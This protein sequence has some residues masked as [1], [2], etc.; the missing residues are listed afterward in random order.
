MFDRKLRL[1]QNDRS[2]G[3][4]LQC[5]CLCPFQ[6]LEDWMSQI[7]TR[8]EFLLLKMHTWIILV[9]NGRPKMLNCLAQV[10]WNTKVRLVDQPEK[11]FQ[12]LLQCAK[13]AY[14]LRVER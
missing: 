7:V 12:R 11:A 10:N 8:F 13:V 6:Q 1:K 14:Q 5:F 4:S 2:W 9:Q 3:I